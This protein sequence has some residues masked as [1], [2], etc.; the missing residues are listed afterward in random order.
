VESMDAPDR[1]L[2]RLVTKVDFIARIDNNHPVPR[3]AAFETVDTVGSWNVLKSRF[4]RCSVLD[5][6]L[7]SRMPLVPM[8]LLLFEALACA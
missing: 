5:G 2:G 7:P 6:I 1:S 4:V 8:P 3:L